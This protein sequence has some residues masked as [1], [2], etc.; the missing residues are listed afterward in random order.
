MRILIVGNFGNG[1]NGDETVLMAMVRELCQLNPAAEITVVSG[2]PA[3]TCKI[4]G[5]RAIR[6]A[7]SFSMIWAIARSDTVIIGGGGILIDQF[8]SSL[9]YGLVILVAKLLGKPTMVY[10]IGLDTV[11][12]RLARAA[13]KLSFNI[14][15]LI[16][17]RDEASKTEMLKLG[18][19][20]TPIYVTADPAFTLDEPCRETFR[21]TLAQAE[22]YEKRS[23]L[24]GI[25]VW[26]TDNL[27]SYQQIPY[28]FADLAD[29]L[30]ETYDCMVVFLVMSTIEFE[31]DLRASRQ[32][33]E[34][35][36]HNDRAQVVGVDYHPQALLAV[37]GQMDLIIGMRYHSLVLPAVAGVPLVGIERSK[38]PKNTYFL[39]EVQ[40]P[41]GGIAENLTV[42]GLMACVTKAWRERV[43][44]TRRVILVRKDL[45]TRA[46]QNVELFAQLMSQ[47]GI[48]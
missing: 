16:S 24:I 27:N 47:Y 3:A 39:R 35:M 45:R 29:R 44:L 4:H 2:D 15:D 23:P 20:G 6:R 12:K 30:V 33:V 7:L 37:F 18:V 42:E 34:M 19:T 13:I 1:N 48:G 17:L 9:K 28:V 41:S 40:Q 11:T 14:V 10:A 32:I 26:P 43:D 21:E 46:S 8:H 38:Y 36:T 5:V 31:G 22:I 25:S